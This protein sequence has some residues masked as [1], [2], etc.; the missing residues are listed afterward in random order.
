M[1]AVII[2]LLFIARFLFKTLVFA[3]VLYILAVLILG[4]SLSFLLIWAVSV[5]VYAIF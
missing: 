3:A 2:I 5:I 4:F 1:L